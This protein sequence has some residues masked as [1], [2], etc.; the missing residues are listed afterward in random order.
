MKK[1]LE[2][3]KNLKESLSKIMTENNV[4]DQ[5]ILNLEKKIIE[6]DSV[7]KQE[8]FGK[9]KEDLIWQIKASNDK[10]KC[11]ENSINELKD[12]IY[13]LKEV[14]NN[15][16]IEDTNIYLDLKL[17]PDDPNQKMILLEHELENQKEVSEKLKA[18][19]G[20]VLENVT[21]SNRA[22]LEGKQSVN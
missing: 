21:I 1:K 8:S 9:R 14:K 22:V 18:Y 19:V 6:S 7:A 11:Q 16:M 5:K 4:T 20:E 17:E 3:V 15:N 2:E 10:I 12:E 13:N